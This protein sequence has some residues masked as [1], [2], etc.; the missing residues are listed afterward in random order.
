ME[1]KKGCP[2]IIDVKYPDMKSRFNEETKRKP[3]MIIEYNK[4]MG[5]VDKLNIFRS[6]YDVACKKFWRFLYLF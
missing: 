5:G 2:H 3:N 1:R 4:S 6:F